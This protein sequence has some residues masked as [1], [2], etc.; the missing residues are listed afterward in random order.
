[1]ATKVHE[2]V[3]VADCPKEENT[4]CFVHPIT[5]NYTDNN[6]IV[7]MQSMTQK[8]G[9]LMLPVEYYADQTSF[10]RLITL[11]PWNGFQS[12][13]NVIRGFGNDK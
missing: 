2:G 3:S 9:R 1:M 12:A 6:L 4:V 8:I 7:R 11:I 13:C 5:G 10:G